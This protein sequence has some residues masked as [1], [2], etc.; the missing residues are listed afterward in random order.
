LLSEP[1]G[2]PLARDWIEGARSIDRDAALAAGMS[3]RA[4]EP[5]GLDEALAQL[6][7]RTQRL[8]L[9]TQRAIHA[10]IDAGRRPR[11][12]AG[13]AQDLLRLVRSAARPGLR[14]RIAAYRH[15][16]LKRD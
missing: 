13:D 9:P 6:I 12:D 7:A 11:G 14:D 4:I 8:A 10:A 15:A 16:Q 2:P 5:E 1:V 3:T